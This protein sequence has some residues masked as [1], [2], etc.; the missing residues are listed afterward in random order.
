MNTIR[1]MLEFQMLML[2]NIND[3]RNKFRKELKK[4]RKW[5]DFHDLIILKGWLLKKF[6]QQHYDLIHEVL[7]HVPAHVS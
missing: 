4:S 5:L 6:S 3:D 2:E 1:N 7:P